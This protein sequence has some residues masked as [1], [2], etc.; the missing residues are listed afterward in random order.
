MKKLKKLFCICV[1]IA[2]LCAAVPI[3]SGIT[4]L[5]ETYECF[6]Y[7]V[8]NG[9]VTITDCDES[10]MGEIVIPD[11]INGYPVTTIGRQAFDWCEN[12]TTIQLPNSVKSIEYASFYGCYSLIGINLPN[13]VTNIGNSAFRSCYDLKSIIIPESISE[14]GTS[15]FSDCISL[16]NIIL[17]ST[18]I[19]IGNSAFMNCWCLE[20]IT[21]P[22]KVTYI[23]A[24]AFENCSALVNIT[25][26]NNVTVI[27]NYA[28]R[29]CSNLTDITIAD[30]IK[31]IGY[32]T[33]SGCTNL[34]D[35]YYNGTKEEWNII[36]IN[37]GNDYLLNAVV[38]FI[39][40][41]DLNCNEVTNAEDLTLFRQLL[42]SGKNNIFADMTD[43]GEIDLRD[44]V[45]LK[46]K[47]AGIIA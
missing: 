19:K 8:S 10:V 36:A 46:K 40:T 45:R 17:P 27:D 30:S 47:L 12:I 28:F 20:N 41:G 1:C 2:L 39:N 25:I 11:T 32:D 24:W 31:T 9:E 13:G 14:I 4:A 21:I 16:T 6:T 44:F 3:V 22:L 42:L 34:T 38:H 35:V 43:D 18:I 23:G 26:P 7:T 5:A 37:S 29:N 33:F 15:V